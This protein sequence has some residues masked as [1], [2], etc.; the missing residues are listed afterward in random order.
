MGINN[1]DARAVN[2]GLGFVQWFGQGILLVKHEWQAK[3]QAWVECAKE[4]S[5]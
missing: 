3:E 5:P 1:H 2:G 4:S